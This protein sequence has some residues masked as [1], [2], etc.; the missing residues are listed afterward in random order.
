MTIITPRL[1]PARF[2]AQVTAF[3]ASF[4][5]LVSIV[6]VRES[7]GW[8]SRSVERTWSFAAGGVAL[9][10]LLAVDAAQRRLVRRLDTRLADEV[11][12]LVAL[13]LEGLERLGVDRARVADD[14]RHE[15]AV[16]VVALRLHRDLDAGQREALLGDQVGRLDRDVLGDPDEV[17]PRTGIRVDRD[18]D[19][20]LVD[21]EQRRQASDDLRRAS[22]TADPTGR[23]LIA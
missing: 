2:I 17:E 14:L 13:V 15:R 9:D 18:V 16:G 21:P 10:R 7:P 6:S 4:C 3:S 22:R 12:G 11:V 5:S 20:C 19:V 1:S 23:I 8:A